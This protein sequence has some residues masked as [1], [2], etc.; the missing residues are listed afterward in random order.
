M[1][2]S[3]VLLSM[4][5]CNTAVYCCSVVARY[6]ENVDW[7]Q[8]MEKGTYFIYDKRGADVDAGKDETLIPR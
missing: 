7:L 1:R 2:T 6:K 3:L 8:F 4:L 5:Y